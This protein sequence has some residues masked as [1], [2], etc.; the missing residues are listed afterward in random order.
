MCSF[1]VAL[2][3]LQIRC[4]FRCN[5]DKPSNQAE[6]KPIIYISYTFTPKN[7]LYREVAHD[8]EKRETIH[9]RFIFFKRCNLPEKARNPHGN[10]AFRGYTYLLKKGVTL[11]KDELWGQF[12]GGR[13]VPWRI[14]REPYS[15]FFQ[16]GSQPEDCNT[17]QRQKSIIQD[18]RCRLSLLLQP[19][20]SRGWVFAPFYHPR[21][22]KK[23]GRQRQCQGNH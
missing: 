1:A 22:F 14:V 6:K 4:N 11:H 19:E 12:F 21:H 13:I 2:L 8:Q 23:K 5:L 10:R 18:K 9:I 20:P 16:S 3:H 17:N 7:I 15:S